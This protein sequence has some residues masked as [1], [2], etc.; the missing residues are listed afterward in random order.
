MT[1]LN[2]FMLTLAFVLPVAAA[3]VYVFLHRRRAAAMSAL[4]MSVRARSHLPYILFLAAMPLLLAGLARPQATVNVPRVSGTV[5]LV[6]DVS[7]SMAAE[8]LAPTRLAAAQ[9]AATSF[10]E[11]QPDTVDVGV[12]VFGQSALMTQAPTSDHDKAIAAIKRMKTNGGTSLGQAI[13]AALSAIV[14]KP[15][16]LPTEASPQPPDLGYWGSATIVL[17]SDGEDNMGPEVED[18]ALLAADA[19][20][21]IQTI[22]IGT[23][24]GAIIEVDGYQVATALNEELLTSVAE[25]T[26]GTYHP[27]RDTEAL[28]DVTKSINLRLRVKEETAELTAV[29]AGAALLLLTIGGLLMTRSYGRIV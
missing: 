28:N 16:S 26:G 5:I 15:V 22:G 24:E 7:N 4:G 19:G 11:A 18:A 25:L 6:F 8:D 29:L 2:P 21:R 23:A 9:A 3:A 1:F 12:V 13:L 20:V 14:G 17:L 10:V 27:A